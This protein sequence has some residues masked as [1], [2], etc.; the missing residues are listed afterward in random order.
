MKNTFSIETS[1]SVKSLS[2]RNGKQA[3]ENK[4]KQTKFGVL[5][6]ASMLLESLNV[7]HTLINKTDVADM[8]ST[9]AT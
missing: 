1:G 8:A 6:V 9:S 2:N 4:Y 3:K 5:N 7:E